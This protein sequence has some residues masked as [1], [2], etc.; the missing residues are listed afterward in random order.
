MK[1]FRALLTWHDIFFAIIL[2]AMLLFSWVMKEILP[3]VVPIHWDIMGQ[4][5]GWGSAS[6]AAWIA[7][8]LAAFLWLLL[9]LVPLADPLKANL[10]AGRLAYG[11]VRLALGVFMGLLDAATLG[12]SAGLTG[13]VKIIPLA[14][15]LLFMV[16]GR[17][18]PRVGRNGVM[19]I[20]LPSTL[21][22]DRI[23]KETHQAAGRAFLTAG[24]ATV[25]ASLLPMPWPF[26]VLVVSAVGTVAVSFIAAQ[27]AARSARLP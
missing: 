20:R 5:N 6:V 27:R 24:L 13:A 23:W 25:L 14:I 4:P 3:P 19:G 17:N 26:L 18:L 21:G 8:G 7:P 15:G 12:A 9:M 2:L 11:E 10:V 1:T 22:S 16:L